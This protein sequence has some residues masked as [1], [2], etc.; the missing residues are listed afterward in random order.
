VGKLIVRSRISGDNM[1]LSGGT[2][3]L[4]KMYI[5]RKIPADLRPF[6]PVVA[7]DLGVLAVGEIGINADRTT[8][9]SAVCISFL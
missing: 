2:K 7:D 4:K 9:A 1:R 5:D 8:G 3:S 6:L